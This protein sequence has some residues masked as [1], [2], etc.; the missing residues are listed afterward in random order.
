MSDL[1]LPSSAQKQSLEERRRRYSSHDRRTLLDYSASRGLE[2]TVADR[3]GLGIVPPSEDRQEIIGRLAIP[4]L[5]A[6]SILGFKFRCIDPVHG[7]HKDEQSG[8]CP[9]YIGD[10]GFHPPMYNAGSLLEDSDVA[11]ICEGEIDAITVHALT[12]YPA[13][14]VPGVSQWKHQDNGFWPRCFSGFDRVIVPADGDKPG[15]ELAKTIAKD[16]QE[17]SVVYLPP[18]T[19]CNSFIRELG[20]AA[21]LEKC[22]LPAA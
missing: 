19:D 7:D 12:G 18:G 2:E 3:Y 8:R 17:T 4:Y 13:A 5:T 15:Q 11:F 21:F 22:D 16:I 20:V 14:G 6:N 9:K 1:R 10:P